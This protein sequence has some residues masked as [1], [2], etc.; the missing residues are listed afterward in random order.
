[1]IPS[2][3]TMLSPLELAEALGMSKDTLAY[4]RS[5]KRGPAYYSVGP[6]I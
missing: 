3:D 6:K 1:M 5:Q 2:R 4:W